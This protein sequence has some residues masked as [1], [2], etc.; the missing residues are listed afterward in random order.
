MDI[1]DNEKIINAEN[2]TLSAQTSYALRHTLR[3]QA[4]LIN[5]LLREGY[6]FVLT[7]KFQSDPIEKRFG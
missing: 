5:G 7:A 6:D 3:C 4:N 1:W 2:F